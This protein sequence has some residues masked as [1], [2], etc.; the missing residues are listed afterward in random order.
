MMI[1][2]GD[3]YYADLRPVI[4]S[5]QGG[6]RP[7]LIIQNDMGNKHS[8]TTIV[9]PITSVVKRNH[10]P[11]HV[12]IDVDCLD[13]ISIVLLEQIRTIDKSRLDGYIG[14]LDKKEERDIF[15][16]NELFGM[17]NIRTYDDLECYMQAIQEA[18]DKVCYVK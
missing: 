6:I 7:V 2:R 17:L 18:Q 3:I 13:E 10:M 5:E 12:T 8:P 4:G 16:V 15:K 11:T 1:R 9:A 14:L